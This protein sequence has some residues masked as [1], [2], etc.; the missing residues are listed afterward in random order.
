MSP[1][2][3]GRLLAEHVS[4]LSEAWPGGQP[5]LEVGEAMIRR[6]TYDPP[7]AYDVIP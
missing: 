1:L 7:I 3:C 2:L 4:M 5:P 6:I